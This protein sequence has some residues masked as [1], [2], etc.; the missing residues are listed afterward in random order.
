[1]RK[2][3][4]ILLLSICASQSGQAQSLFGWNISLDYNF[5]NT[6]KNLN[7][8][9]SLKSVAQDFSPIK[10]G[11]L[12]LGFPVNI[13]LANWILLRPQL[14]MNISLGQLDYKMANGINQTAKLPSLNMEL[15]I[16][17]VISNYNKEHGFGLILGARG[18]YKVKDLAKEQLL[19]LTK[20]YG[21]LDAG[22]GYRF[23]MGKKTTVMPE[24]RYSFGL[25]DLLKQDAANVYA[26]T[27]DHV[28][29]NRVSFVLNFF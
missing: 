17:M 2:I 13:K 3:F 7:N 15:P 20:G 21:T 8:V 23:K 5:L 9:D 4:F 6:L 12:S 19:M 29:R 27:L 1:M 22:L 11:G 16:Q 24:F 26:Y 28:R 25:N 18:G 14:V 10:A